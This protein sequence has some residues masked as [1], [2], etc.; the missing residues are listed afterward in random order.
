VAYDWA[1]DGHYDGAMSLAQVSGIVHGIPS[2]TSSA[3]VVRSTVVLLAVG[4][5]ALLVI[6]GAAYWLGQRAQVYFDDAL[7]ARDTRSAAVELRNAIQAAEASQRGYLYTGNQIYLA[8][9]S[10]ARRNALGQFEIVKQK[11]SPSGSLSPALSRLSEIIEEKFAEMD[12]TIGLKRAR[13]N[14]EAFEIFRTNRGKALMD[15]ANVFLS[16]I[17]R[18]A[19]GRLTTGVNEQRENASLL[20]LVT[21]LAGFLIV[22]VVAAVVYMVYR[23]AGELALARDQVAGLASTL[24]KRV[25]Q[26]TAD[27]TRARDRAEILLSEVNHRVANSLALVA[28]MVN[29][30]SRAASNQSAKDILGE[31]QARI[32]AVSLVHKRL[33]S[34]GDVRYVA[35][36]EYLSGL[37]EHLETSM[38][39]AGHNASVSRDL[40][41]LT[42]RTD[43][44][45]NL[46]VVAAE[47]VTNAFKYAYPNRPGEVRVRLKQIAEDRGELVVEDDGIGRDGTVK[48]TGLGT[49]LVHAMAG[50]IDADVQYVERNPGTRARLVFPLE[51][52]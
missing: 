47:W 13:Q 8:P 42:L 43:A 25:E 26:R 27:L 19:D 24:E 49:R 44:S 5:L 50:T 30:Q 17:I 46:G 21:I 4:F 18:A 33:Y 6:V 16:G 41:P 51:A 12:R 10:T 11:L 38:R 34:S 31:V 40:D 48:G 37:L 52:A 9:Y 3:R 35:L 14:D 15:E 22:G 1:E 36:D 2:M 45:I 32:Y 29:L 7:D 39:D 20:R 23:H 28:S